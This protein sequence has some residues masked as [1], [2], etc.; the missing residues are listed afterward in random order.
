M[1]ARCCSGLSRVWSTSLA[2][3]AGT[4]M[5]SLSFGCSP[6]I[7]PWGR[8]FIADTHLNYEIGG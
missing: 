1:Q 4:G 7:P 8:R 6:F 3:Q 2:P 5:F